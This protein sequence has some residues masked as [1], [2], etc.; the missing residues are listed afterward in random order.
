MAR[1]AKLP[2]GLT[3][4]KYKTVDGDTVIKYRYRAKRK[5]FQCDKLF[6]E[7]EDAIEFANQAKTK[8]GKE[9]ILEARQKT[10]ER[11]E[12]LHWMKG[13]GL[14]NLLQKYYERFLHKPETR[15]AN[16][17]SNGSYRA[18]INAICNTRINVSDTDFFKGYASNVNQHLTRLRRFG[19]I[20]VDCITPHHIAE[21]ITTRL[22]HIRI[23]DARKFNSIPEAE[24][25]EEVAERRKKSPR[26]SPATVQREINL[27]GAFFNRLGELSALPA[28]QNIP[29]PV[30]KASKAQ[31]KYDFEKKDIRLDPEDEKALFNELRA[32]SY[33]I[34]AICK[35][36]LL[37][38]MRRNE[39]LTL[40]WSNFKLDENHIQ[41]TKEQ[42]KNG[43]PRKVM[44][45]ERQQIIE[46]LEGLE[47]IPDSDKLFTYTEDGFN[48][49]FKR[50]LKRSG[51]QN[52]TFKDFRAEFI[53]RVLFKG[54]ES[55]VVSE[56]A[57]I[58]SQKHFDKHHTKAFN[59][60]LAMNNTNSLTQDQLK[61]MVGHSSLDI[62]KKHYIRPPKSR[63]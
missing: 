52:F 47:K 23:S 12:V 24:Y 6:D 36:A 11:N 1:I 27:L 34:Y 16:K 59:E 31:L 58:K 19:E 3:P 25:T 45:I 62:T 53:S 35:L 40:T 7:L 63:G 42:T 20:D 18:R 48:S 17:K 50:I 28:L 60:K 54:L 26:I 56:L 61:N 22:N 15:P 37:T 29:N 8:K 41:L 55:V 32:S 39:L 44:L 38:G 5:D 49:T 14:E 9:E 33:P 51:V 21:Y 30:A 10:L 43:R 13:L 46:L 4:V 57:D 2:V